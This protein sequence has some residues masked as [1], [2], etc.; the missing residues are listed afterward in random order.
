MKY[1]AT[2]LIVTSAASLSA[3]GKTE[4]PA[5]PDAPPARA[6]SL[7]AVPAMAAA[8]EAPPVQAAETPAAVPFEITPPKPVA[9]DT[10]SR[11]TPPEPAEVSA[12]PITEAVP[13]AASPD[14]AHGQQIYRQACAFCHDR[15]VAGAPKIGEAAAWSPRLA[16]GKDVL[17]ISALGGKG[18]MPAKGGNP[19]LAAADVKAAVDY[20]VA[21][22]R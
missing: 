13:A 18:A 9:P 12:P 1:A 10:V 21:Q 4:A 8:T 15:G 5:T 11:Y 22:A 7:L 2:F 6:A 19:S 20:L 3:C 16:Q 17:Y 14:L